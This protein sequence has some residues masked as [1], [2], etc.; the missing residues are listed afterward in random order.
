[1]K[2]I[3]GDLVKLADQDHFDMIIHGANCFHTMGSGIARQLA[4]KWPEVLLADKRTRYGDITK[5]G[6]YSVATTKSATGRNF[7][8]VNAYTQFRYGREKQ[9]VDYEA[10]R[11][12]FNLIKG[13]T[14]PHCFRIGYPAI[15]AGLGGGDWNIIS[16]I[17]DEELNG[18]DH[19]LV[20]LR[21]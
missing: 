15:G 16:K 8:V 5:L 18:R 11:N 17:I 6:T 2:T 19:T 14:L 1:M 9:Q 13:I 12:C 10:I 7:S 21:K 20:L 4:L 3:Y